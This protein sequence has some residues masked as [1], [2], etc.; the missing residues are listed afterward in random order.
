MGYHTSSPCLD[1]C[2]IDNHK[3][4]VVQD[5]KITAYPNYTRSSVLA[6]RC[7]ISSWSLDTC[8]LGNII[9]TAVQEL[10]TQFIQGAQLWQ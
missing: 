1:I 6:M 8:R 10:P 3:Y 5:S 7:H 4:M 2:R 9:Y